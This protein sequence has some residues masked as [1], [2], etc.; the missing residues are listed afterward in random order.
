MIKQLLVGM[1]AGLAVLGTASADDLKLG[2]IFVGPKDDYGY[3]QAHAQGETGISGLPGVKT[4]D[5]AQVPE[6]VAVEETMRD[7]I[8]QDSV[9]V[10][11]P[12]SFGYFYPHIIKVAKQFPDVQ[13]L[14]CGGLYADGKTPK[15]VGSYFGYIDEAEYIC[16]I[17]AAST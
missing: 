10:L 1:A 17:V 9:S 14:H 16:G 4:V 15:N 5:E 8:T 3:N 7:M 11:F 13:F 2:F 12:T 6:T